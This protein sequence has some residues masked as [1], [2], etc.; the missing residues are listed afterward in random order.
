VCVDPGSTR[1]AG[2]GAQSA[3]LAHEKGHVHRPASRLGAVALSGARPLL[4]REAAATGLAPRMP[5]WY[6]R[7][8]Q[9]GRCRSRER[10]HTHAPGCW[11]RRAVAR[12]KQRVL[13]AVA[14]SL[15]S[16]LQ[17]LW[18]SDHGA[19][20]LAAASGQPLGTRRTGSQEKRCS[21]VATGPSRASCR[22][23]PAQQNSFLPPTHTL[24]AC[25]PV[26]CAAPRQSQG[27]LRPR[28]GC[29]RSGTTRSSGS[30]CSST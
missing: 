13:E 9:N 28:S 23:L 27:P 21:S 16:S 7:S 2:A 15:H 11:C 3:C 29:P 10:A 5:R 26:H 30:S 17:C 6:A 22:P 18:L 1:Q 4:H 8:V 20:A 25:C 14:R 24:A 12:S 19:T